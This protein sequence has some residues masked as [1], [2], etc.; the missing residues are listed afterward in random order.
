GQDAE[1]LTPSSIR[2]CGGGWIAA[3]RR[4]GRGVSPRA[5][6]LRLS[7][8]RQ[9]LIR[10]AIADATH[11]RSQTGGDRRSPA[12][13]SP[14]RGE[15]KAAGTGVALLTPS[16]CG[17]ASATATAAASTT[18]ASFA[19]ATGTITSARSGIGTIS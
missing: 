13:P 6:L 1:I 8:P 18:G 16:A 11:R 2:P 15:G 17:S 9:P 19:A 14:A 4:D 12:P 5:N 10:R 7:P 3:K